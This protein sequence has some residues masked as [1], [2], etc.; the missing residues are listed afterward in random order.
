MEGIQ[1]NTDSGF[2]DGTLRSA[3]DFH[4]FAQPHDLTL[5]IK[6]AC[7]CTLNDFS[8]RF[9]VRTEQVM[10]WDFHFLNQVSTPSIQDKQLCKSK[11]LL[12]VLSGRPLSAIVWLW[13]M[14]KCLLWEVNIEET[15]SILYTVILGKSFHEFQTEA[16]ASSNVGT[17]NPPFWYHQYRT[18]L[19][20]IQS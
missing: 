16:K 15:C 11:T 9:V 17:Y 20:M 19:L 10:P 13:T 4:C 6:I 5:D 14:S 1:P 2:P 3:F 18:N 7:L 8:A 12:K